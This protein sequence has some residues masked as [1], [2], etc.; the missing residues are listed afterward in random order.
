MSR[1]H[2]RVVGLDARYKWDWDCW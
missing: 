2:V 1:V